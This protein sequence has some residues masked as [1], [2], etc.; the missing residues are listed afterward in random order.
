MKMVQIDI[1]KTNI[2]PVF[3]SFLFLG[4]QEVT[5]IS[6]SIQC[7]NFM[8]HFGFCL[9][10]WNH[11]KW[12][13]FQATWRSRFVSPGSDSQVMNWPRWRRQGS[14]TSG[15]SGHSASRWWRWSSS[16]SLTLKAEPAAANCGTAQRPAETD[17]QTK[18]RKSEKRGGICSY[19][20][21]RSWSGPL[22]LIFSS[23]IWKTIRTPWG[24]WFLPGKLSKRNRKQGKLEQELE[25]KNKN[26]MSRDVH[27]FTRSVSV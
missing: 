1:L 4:E 16:C 10:T 14:Q 27:V 8:S 18:G 13:Y 19:Q 5:P 17:R 3:M 2:F 12:I 23:H 25:C 24:C 20:Q 7:L 15:C 26:K 9:R 21:E 11:T 22:F 6:H